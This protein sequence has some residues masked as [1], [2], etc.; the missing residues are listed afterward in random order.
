MDFGVR[1]VGAELYARDEAY[2]QCLGYGAS[3]WESFYG[4]MVGDSE[5]GDTSLGGAMEKLSGR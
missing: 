5:G 3:F 4:V 1:P 2:A